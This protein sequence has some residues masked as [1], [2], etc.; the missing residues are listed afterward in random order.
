MSNKYKILHLRASNFYGGPER[1]LHLH[2][3]H[4][5]SSDYEITVGSFTEMGQNP[6]FIQRIAHDDISTHC[7][8]IKSSYDFQSVSLVRKY[9][10]D[11][12]ISILCTHDYR[13][14]V[15]GFLATKGTNTKW[16]AFS[17]GWTT[18]DLKI[19]AYNLLDKTI[20][21]FAGHIV[22]VSHAQ[23]RKL[24]SRLISGKKITVV[25]NAIEPDYFKDLNPIY[26]KEK[27]NLPSDS[28]ICIS[29]GRF[30]PEKG[31]L[32][33]I[34]AAIKAIE[35]NNKL[36]FICFGDGIDL[37]RL[38]EIV[39]QSGFQEKI[40]LPGFERTL[41]GCLKGSDMLINPSLSEGL[42]NI[43][44]EAMALRVPV[45]ATSVGGVPEII[46]DDVNGCLI[47]S[48]DIDLMA[49][50]ILMMASNKEKV[51]K[52][53]ENA[54]QLIKNRFTFENQ[55]NELAAIYYRLLS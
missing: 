23:K 4:S 44:L 15:I 54:L 55:F 42:P 53:T 12:K 35:K 52:Y 37:P 48:R 50:K 6:E 21:R 14:Q 2:A 31:Q 33:L 29:G 22:A 36:R 32:F 40:L 46:T 34:K 11:N 1:Q 25:H 8:H 20:L 43:V 17:R 7:F 30:S 13:T 51:Q 19:K 10:K 24:I 47:P 28:I 3:A 5:K 27:Y 18:E 9:L 26:L 41:I 39:A 49:E 38:K 16:M 45:V